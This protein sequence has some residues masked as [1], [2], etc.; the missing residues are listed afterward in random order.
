MA[1]YIE[2]A[3]ETDPTALGDE[4]VAEVQTRIPDW[5]ASPG[6]LETV[7]L[8]A[9]AV[10]LAELRDV[11]SAVPASIFR[12][13]GSRIANLPPLDDA[14]ATVSSTWTALD[15]AGYTIEAG[16][17]V[18]IRAA[19]DELLLFDV[20]ADVVIP[21]GVGATAAGEVAL[22]AEEAGATANALGGVG[23]QAELVDALAWVDTIV[24]TGET[25]GGVDAE[26]DDDYLNRLATELQLQTPRPILPRD[27]A[28]LA[29]RI[30]TV[31]R[32]LAIDLYKPA[33][34]P[35]PGDPAETN[36]PKSVTVAVVDDV[37]EPVPSIVRTQVADLLAAMRET[38]FEVWVVDPTYTT[39]DVTFTATTYP[40]WEAADVEARAEEAV[41]DYL[42]PA[43]WGTPQFSDERAWLLDTKVRLGELFEVLN[44]V[45]G[46]W[47]V[48]TL[49][50][51][52]QGNALA[53]VDITLTGVAPLPRAGV[54]A[55]TVTGP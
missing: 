4:A 11:A 2:P 20:E 55:G 19:G 47:R 45:D 18:G 1:E 9:A 17:T 44:R 33:G 5:E 34:V 15:L 29:Q 43:N 37:G 16:T 12:W 23:A 42:S 53:A 13:F 22:V 54:I 28:V 30:P 26:P 35:N 31:D 25:G 39:V 21:A 40:N 52:I 7:L 14:P 8:Y 50:F 51:A 3:I 48:D 24:L 27:F 36:R 38:N 46:L 49:T 10:M 32:A 6:N 41:T